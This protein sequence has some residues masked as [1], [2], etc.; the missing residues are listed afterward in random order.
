[1]KKITYYIEFGIIGMIVWCILYENVTLSI[2]VTGFLMAVLATLF[3]GFFLSS[4]RIT[5][6]YRLNIPMLAVFVV[7]LLFRIIKAGIQVIPYIISRKPNTGIID[8]ETEVPEGLAATTLANSITL[9]PGT[10]TVDKNGRKIKVLWLDKK[11]DDPVEAAR[12]INGPLERI[13]KKAAKNG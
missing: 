9:T 4:H 2:A 12:I 8:I 11:T 6:A 10:V 5:S 1:M 13:L 7:V 3:A